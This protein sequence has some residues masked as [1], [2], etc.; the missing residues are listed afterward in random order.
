M[1]AEITLLPTFSCMFA[2]MTLIPT[3]C[4]EKTSRKLHVSLRNSFRISYDFCGKSS[5]NGEKSVRLTK[6]VKLLKDF[7]RFCEK[8]RENCEILKGFLRLCEK[9]AKLLNNFLR[10]LRKNS[11]NLH[12][13]AKFLKDFWRLAFWKR[14]GEK[15]ILKTFAKKVARIL[16]FAIFLL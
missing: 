4:C 12:F 15:K 6:I 10:L 1:F 14:G 3:F 8:S 11:R 5:E 7:L 13:F 16:F 9:S 2:K